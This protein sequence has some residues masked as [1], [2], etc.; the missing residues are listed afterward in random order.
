MKNLNCKKIIKE[1]FLLFRVFSRLTE[2]ECHLS[3]GVIHFTV[4]DHDMR[5]FVIE[6]LGG[7]GRGMNAFYNANKLEKHNDKK[8]KLLYNP[9]IRFK[10]RMY[11]DFNVAIKKIKLRE[12]LTKL[13]GNP[14]I[15]LRSKVPEEIYDT[16]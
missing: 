5:I 6:G 4:M 13:M 1:F 7:T 10:Y 16:L 14:D 9:E 12:T 2:K 11:L 15:Y 3:G 8:Y